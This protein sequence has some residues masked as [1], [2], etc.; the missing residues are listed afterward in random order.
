MA[1]Q[2]LIID[3]QLPTNTM[4]LPNIDTQLPICDA[5]LPTNTMK[6]RNID[7]SCLNLQI[8]C[9]LVIL[10]CLPFLFQLPRIHLKG[11]PSMLVS[12]LSMKLSCLP[13]QKVL[14]ATKDDV[15][16]LACHGKQL[17]IMLA[18]PRN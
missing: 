8:S 1:A 10:C 2:L 15:K 9:L 16:L 4:K 13:Y 3:Y 18:Y 5:Q 7:I 17:R 12:C 14:H 6:L 11:G